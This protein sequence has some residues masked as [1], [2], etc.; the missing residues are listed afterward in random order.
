M[1]LYSLFSGGILEVSKYF[2]FVDY[3]ERLH[4]LSDGFLIDSVICSTA[5]FVP[6]PLSDALDP[7]FEERSVASRAKARR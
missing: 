7:Q 5:T 6:A 3:S 1:N 2:Y 4:Q